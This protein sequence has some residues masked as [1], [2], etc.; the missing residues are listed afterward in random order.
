MT[1]SEIRIFRSDRM[2]KKYAAWQQTI[3]H[4]LNIEF[5]NPCL[6][7]DSVS[8]SKHVWRFRLQVL[9][10]SCIELGRSSTLDTLNNKF[11]NSLIMS[12]RPEH[13]APPEIVSFISLSL[14]QFN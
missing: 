12:G 9:A 6:G 1:P 7:V 4:V 3:H 14:S 10:I 5:H 13:Q 2:V 11:I 8:P